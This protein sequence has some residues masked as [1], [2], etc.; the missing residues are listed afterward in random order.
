ML[1]DFI[2]GAIVLILI[3]LGIYKG[4]TG[5]F[6]GTFSIILSLIISFFLADVVA[7]QIFISPLGDTLVNFINSKLA[8]FGEVASAPI[9]KV[10][11][12]YFL[13][14]TEGQVAIADAF[15]SMGI[16]GKIFG[17]YAVKIIPSLNIEGMSLADKFVPVIAKLMLS[18]MSGVILFIL[19]AIIFKILG[20]VSENWKENAVFNKI[21]KVLGTLLMAFIGTLLINFCMLAAAEAPHVSVF[22]ALAEMTDGTF[23]SK[24][25][26]EHNILKAALNGMGV[27]T[28]ELFLRYFPA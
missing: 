15:N 4:L 28:T 19:A 11:S 9:I 5:L 27:D 25:F 22:N 12:D 18:V 1:L 17:S 3:A 24:F 10:G 14:T 6:F 16:F 7:Q 20:K 13:D 2:F 23:I 26:Y 21:D 8:A